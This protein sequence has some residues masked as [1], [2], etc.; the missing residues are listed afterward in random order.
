MLA[1]FYLPPKNCY[2]LSLKDIIFSYTNECKMYDYM[3]NFYILHGYYINRK[4]FGNSVLNCNS[5]LLEIETEIYK[6]QKE[7]C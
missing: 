2:M 1:P 7:V 4:K 6:Q 3:V 5:V